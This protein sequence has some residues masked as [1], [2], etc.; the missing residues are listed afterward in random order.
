MANRTGLTIG[1]LI[2][3]IV[4]LLGFV[5]FAFLVKPTFEGYVVQKQIDAQVSVFDFLAQQSQQNNGVIQ[6]PVGNQTWFFVRLDPQA[7]QQVQ[8]P[9][10]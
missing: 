1:F 10:Q 8:P 6:I 2:V 9:I 4:I 3:V 7:Q 5:L